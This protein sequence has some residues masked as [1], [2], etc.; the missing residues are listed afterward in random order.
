MR[1]STNDHNSR[2]RLEVHPQL[3][4]AIG[5]QAQ[6]VVRYLL[7]Q[8]RLFFGFIPPYLEVLAL[9][10][11]GQVSCGAPLLPEK[12]FLNFALPKD[13]IGA[14]ATVW[15]SPAQTEKGE[16]KFAATGAEVR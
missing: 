10:S 6:I 14:K 5:T 1:T 4:L 9:D 15:G 3:I 8:I 2:D 11:T 13:K 16:V 12:K 7:E